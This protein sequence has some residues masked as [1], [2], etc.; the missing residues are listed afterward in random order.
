MPFTHATTTTAE[1]QT[2][3]AGPQRDPN[4]YY[5][6]C[7]CL[8]IF[9]TEGSSDVVFR[10]GVFTPYVGRSLCTTAARQ[11]KYT[12]NRFTEWTFCCWERRRRRQTFVYARTCAVYVV[13][14]YTRLLCLRLAH[15]STDQLLSQNFWAEKNIAVTLMFYVCV[16]DKYV[17]H[18]RSG[19]QTTLLLR[20]HFITT[21][22][23]A[24]RS[25]RR[26]TMLRES[27]HT[28]VAASVAAMNEFTLRFREIPAK[29]KQHTRARRK[30]PRHACVCCVFCMQSHTRIIITC[31]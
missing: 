3:R 27:T 21:N 17:G 14:G 8:C 23:R 22:A 10:R 15:I 6:L 16:C 2:G 12:L 25:R 5:Y 9:A 30:P 24:I 18:S 11:R 31:R 19:S 4:L 28:N 26:G 20:P 7:V 29:R 1:S 13:R